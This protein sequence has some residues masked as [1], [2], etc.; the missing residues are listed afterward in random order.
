MNET[1]G[2]K[3]DKNKSLAFCCSREGQL[4]NIYYIINNLKQFS[5]CKNMVIRVCVC[6]C[7]CVHKCVS[8]IT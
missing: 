4:R 5:H 8:V 7:V 2:E 1:K 3:N 6:V